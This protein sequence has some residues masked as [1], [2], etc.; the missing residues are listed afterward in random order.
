MKSFRKLAY[1]LI[2]AFIITNS[3]AVEDVSHELDPDEKYLFLEAIIRHGSRTA[4]TNV[5]DDQMTKD[6]GVGELTAVGS[7]QQY[8][9]GKLM[10]EKYHTFINRKFDL[11][12]IWVRSSGFDRTIQSASDLL[13]GMFGHFPSVPIPFDTTDEKMFPQWK[14]YRNEIKPAQIDFN[15]SLPIN[16]VSYPIW[17]LGQG[18]PDLFLKADDIFVN[19]CN[20]TYP[21]RVEAGERF[22]DY[23]SGS[24]YVNFFMQH[25][26]HRFGMVEDAFRGL[27]V[28]NK[29]DQLDLQN[30]GEN[31]FL[32]ADAVLAQYENNPEFDLKTN[33]EYDQFFLNGAE[34]LYSLSIFEFYNSTTYNKVVQTPILENIRNNINLKV[35]I[36]NGKKAESEDKQKLVILSAHD[37]TIAQILMNNGY[38]DTTCLIDFVKYSKASSDDIEITE[39][40]LSQ[41]IKSISKNMLQDNQV[42]KEATKM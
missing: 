35:D 10:Q 23:L 1:I 9:L 24:W 36:S 28:F 7:R 20:A 41:D 2:V 16:F 17:S 40:N 5:I 34:V 3:K 38:I 29:S 25:A 21:L 12:E 8:L 31:T 30:F 27:G 15:T 11:N 33:N 37:S 14:N 32:I 18:V 39:S 13:Q 19:S 22:S 4:F 6:L 42:Q 26:F